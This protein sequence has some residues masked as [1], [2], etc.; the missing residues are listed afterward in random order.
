MAVMETYNN[1]TSHDHCS[2]GCSHT[3]TLTEVS[4]MGTSIQK[5]PLSHQ[6][7]C[8][9]TYKSPRTKVTYYLSPGPNKW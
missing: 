7:L 4:G 2:W 8:N 9:I 5:V 3:L 6:H 1:T